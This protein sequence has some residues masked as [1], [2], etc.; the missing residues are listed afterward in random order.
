M[1][2]AT[3]TSHLIEIFGGLII[4][5]EE[6]LGLENGLLHRDFE[7]VALS[8][9]SRGVSVFMLDL[10]SLCSG[11]EASLESGNT[12]PMLGLPFVKR[13]KPTIFGPLFAKIFA[14]DGG[15][16]C[17]PCAESLR[18][19][20]QAFRFAKKYRIDA[21]IDAVKEKYLE[22]ANIE[23][24]LH[25][26]CL[27][28]GSNDLSCS[29]GFP[30]V[31]DL[32]LKLRNADE[33]LYSTDTESDPISLLGALG[34]VQSVFDGFARH[35]QFREEWF[36]PKHGP[37]A[38]SEEYSSSKFEF[39]SWGY[40]LELKFPFDLWGLASHQIWEGLPP[41]DHTPPCKLIGVPK[42]YRG[43]RLIASEPI[44]SQ[45]IQ[46][47]LLNVLRENVKRS[48]LRHCI[49]FRSQQPSRD[50]VL[51]ASLTREL[52]TIDLS[53]ASDRLSC[54]LVECAFRRKFSFLEL[55]NAARTPESIYPDGKIV[56]LKK[57]AAQGAAFTFP[58]QSIIYSL[59]CMGVISAF[60][61]ETRLS[62]L[63]KEV[64]VF[65]DDM[66]VPTRYFD[67][68]CQVL[69]CLQLKVNRGKSFAKGYFRESCGM[70][71]FHGCDVTPANV[72]TVF[73]SDDPDTLVSTV[74]CANNLFAK[75]FI[76]ASRHL[77][78]TIPDRWTKRNRFAK[79]KQVF[80]K[81]DIC[82]K[83]ISSTVFGIVSGGRQKL[84]KRRW[85]KSLHRHEIRILVV[86]SE[87]RKSQTDG[88][89]RLIQW[90]HEKPR[91]DIVWVPGEVLSVKARYRLR[92][93]R[94]DLVS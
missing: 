62:V 47:G 57:F 11:L 48:P 78:D 8:A 90:F 70:D 53:S 60:T 64:R 85:N 66:I 58:V 46:Q 81:S 12:G 26:P 16:L 45:F 7:K 54:A 35:I 82:Y 39:P 27:T 40:R 83:G 84:L 34:R 28:W 75:G 13:G 43:P 25:S 24:Q 10:P 36:T 42:D 73:N 29:S 59:I 20:R 94:D 37:G 76:N 67:A 74:E 38:V 18:C 22:F 19:L 1:D 89:S 4:D 9:R 56:Q 15:I 65:G 49:D 41:V 52:S 79:H 32:G 91:P 6:I 3:I 5:I 14:E 72:L 2:T 93:V 88:H 71:A 21:P 68:I 92:W 31:V 33:C 80:R 44:A 77:L 61:E 30:S 51:G 23:D 87:V 55:L 17:E 63:A 69:E 86:E 50:L